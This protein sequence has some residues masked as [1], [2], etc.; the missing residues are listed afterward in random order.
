M[1]FP[2]TLGLAAAFASAFLPGAARG[3]GYNIYEQSASVLGMGGAGTA[4]VHD[5][6][7][8]FFNPAALTRLERTQVYLG[9]SLL[10]PTTSFAG[11]NPYPGYGVTEEMK[12]QTFPL[13]TFYLS[14]R[15]NER[16]ALG[17]GFNAPFG[18]GVEWK[19]PDQFTGRYIV[20][21]ADLRAVNTNLSAAYAINPR[22]SVALGGNLTWARVS[23]ENRRFTPAPGGGGAQLE[24][25]KVELESDYTP[26][27]GWNAAVN[28]VADKSWTFGA[29]YRGKVI[30]DAE[31]NADFTQIPTGN[32]A[33]DA[34]VAA[35]LPPDQPVSTVLRLP[36]IWSVGAAW[37]L[38]ERITLEGDVN[39][40]EW[41]LFKDLPVYF[42]QTPASNERIIEDYDDTWRYTFGAEHRLTA[43]TYRFGYY[44]E[45]AAAPVASLSPILPDAG[46]NGGTLGLGC[47]FGKD[48]QWTLDLYELALF[49]QHRHTEL[50]NRDNYNGHYKSFVN[51]SGFSLGYRW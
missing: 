30:V 18:L 42:Q 21:R 36:A 12:A 48:K 28:F 16:A 20:T 1:K 14:H 23:L 17:I 5:A 13:P 35:Q 11:V 39:Y 31:G 25:A 9:G 24:V 38:G 40:T 34:A 29:F 45:E 15:F 32:P 50:A 33:V 4:S 46:R 43:F 49:I 3:A 51:A 19:D 27:Y 8:V 7:A 47:A 37:N 6:S 22:L 2:R 44:Y 41:S 26:G 10:M